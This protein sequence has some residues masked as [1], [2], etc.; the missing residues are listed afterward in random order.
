MKKCILT[1]VML[2]FAWLLP[3]SL[4]QECVHVVYPVE[5]ILDEGEPSEGCAVE[6][7][8]IAEVVYQRGF[9]MTQDEYRIGWKWL[10]LP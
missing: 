7:S 2:L 10:K 5:K 6:P 4:F 1:G 8:E 9:D 3:Q